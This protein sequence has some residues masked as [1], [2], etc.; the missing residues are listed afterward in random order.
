MAP[1]SCITPSP[2]MIKRPFS[3][4]PLQLRSYDLML[5]ICSRTSLSISLLKHYV[6]AS[7]S[8]RRVR[9]RPLYHWGVGLYNFLGPLWIGWALIR[10]GHLFDD[11]LDLITKRLFICKCN[12]IKQSIHGITLKEYKAEKL[13]KLNIFGLTRHQQ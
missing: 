1:G 4:P 2:Q 6:I 3:E 9:G 13:K 7:Q 11:L 8:Q 10:G 12:Y 5:L